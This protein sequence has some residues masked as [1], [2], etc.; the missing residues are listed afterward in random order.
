MKR[1]DAEVKGTDWDEE[2]PELATD[3]DGQN[4]AM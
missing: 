2:A 4:M 3:S 1:K